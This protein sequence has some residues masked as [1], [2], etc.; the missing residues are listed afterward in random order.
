MKRYRYVITQSEQGACFEYLT[1]LARDILAAD[2]KALAE[3]PFPMIRVA[4][5]GPLPG[6]D[7][8]GTKAQVVAKGDL[9]NTNIDSGPPIKY[10]TDL[11]TYVIAGQEVRP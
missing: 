1:I 8:Q 4:E 7:L 3:R 2:E 11:R 6:D 5:E 10:D 9:S